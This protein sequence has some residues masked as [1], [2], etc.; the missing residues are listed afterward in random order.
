MV[1]HKLANKRRILVI[2]SDNMCINMHAQ[3]GNKILARVYMTKKRCLKVFKWFVWSAIYLIAHGSNTLN[4]GV[5]DHFAD[6]LSIGKLISKIKCAKTD[7]HTHT[8]YPDRIIYSIEKWLII[9]TCFFYPGSF[10]YKRLSII[11]HFN[12]ST[13]IYFPQT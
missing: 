9:G 6:R 1:R 13:K 7:T 10:I 8:M 5:F 11:D 4:S 3:R 12:K 2:S